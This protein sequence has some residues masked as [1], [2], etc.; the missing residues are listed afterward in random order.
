MAE[1]G[2]QPPS[3]GPWADR[4]PE[5]PR[6]PD[7]KEL[8]ESRM[9]FLEHIGELRL[10]VRNSVI[11]LFAGFVVAYSFK[12]EILVLL[13]RPLLEVWTK[14]HAANPEVFGKATLNFGSL[15]EPFWTYFSIGI[16]GGV[17]LASPLIFY[18][19]WKFV[20]PGLYKHERRWGMTF[21]MASAVSFI[22]GAVFCYFL[23]LPAVYDFLLGYASSDLANIKSSLGTHYRL[24]SDSVALQPTL[25]IQ[26]Y[27]K[28]ARK[29]LLGFGIVFEL[30]L[31]IFF[32]SW[33]GMVN[34]RTLWKFNRWWIVCS[35]ILSAILTPPDIVSQ[36]LMAG[37]LIVLYN[38]S[39][40]ISFF[41]TRRRERRNAAYL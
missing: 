7:E 14:K 26:E 41:I 1:P 2:Q 11:A 10:R 37:P 6:R 32:L 9:S 15:I 34:H 28:F 25:F 33:I 27:L 8:D 4:I 38:I 19:L 20:A 39:I 36:I 29:L 23:V 13:L 22:G 40:V 31:L 35:F 30:P 17:F 12:E 16:W 5:Q 24:A 18:Q 3:R 21:A